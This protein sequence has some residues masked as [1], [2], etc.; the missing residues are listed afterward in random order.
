M[1][2]VVIGDERANPTIEVEVFSDQLEAMRRADSL[3]TEWA[4]P[5]EKIINQEPDSRIGCVF[6]YYMETSDIVI[7]VYRR[8]VT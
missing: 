7:K 8:P 4:H 1:Y 3:I 6:N 5:E 2:C